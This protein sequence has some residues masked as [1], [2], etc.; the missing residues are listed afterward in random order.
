MISSPAPMFCAAPALGDQV[1]GLG[2][3]AHE[4]DLVLDAAPMKRRTVSRASS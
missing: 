4:D 3:A 1:D 2:G